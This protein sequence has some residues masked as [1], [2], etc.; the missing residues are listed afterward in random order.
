MSRPRSDIILWDKSVD[1]P[2]ILR[3]LHIDK[4]AYVTIR[5][6]IMDIIHDNVDFFYERGVSRTM[7]DF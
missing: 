2:G 6:S 5:Q 4:D 3:D 7:L 1:Q